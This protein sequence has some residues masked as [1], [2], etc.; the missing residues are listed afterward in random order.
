MD[1]NLNI[2]QFFLHD[3]IAHNLVLCFMIIFVVNCFLET[4][5][6]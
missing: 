5:V 1:H 2:K 3:D 4:S 6:E